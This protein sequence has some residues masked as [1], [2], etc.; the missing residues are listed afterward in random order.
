ME[1]KGWFVIYGLLLLLV[2]VLVV[3]NFSL[4]GRITKLE[5]AASGPVPA[6]SAEPEVE[7]SDSPEPSPTPDLS[8]PANRD[9]VRKAALGEI[10]Q[11]LVKYQ[12]ANQKYP[13]T[14]QE[15]VSEFLPAVPTDPL[16][17]KF[18]Y[19]YAKVGTGYRLTA[20]LESPSDADDAADGKKD[21]IYT[22]TPASQ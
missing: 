6:E 7:T 14:L 11:A 8:T 15:L 17:P 5:S 1:G 18:A 19:R 9:A 10:R 13:N 12:Q 22:L 2:I 4:S 16:A 20:A 21:K 3:W